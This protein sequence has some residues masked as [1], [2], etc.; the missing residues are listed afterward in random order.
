MAAQAFGAEV[1]ELGCRLALDDFGVGFGSFT[2]LRSLPISY[3]KI[4]RGFVGQLAHSA[5]DRRV[6]QGIV[7][8]ARSF[9]IEMIA[10]GIEDEQ[11]RDVLR[12]FGVDCVQGFLLGLPQLGPTAAGCATSTRSPG[13]RG[14]SGGARLDEMLDVFEKV[15]SDSSVEHSGRF[16]EIPPSTFDLRPAG[17]RAAEAGRDPG[18]LRRETRVNTHAGETMAET[19]EQVRESER[20][21]ADGVHVD[22]TYTAGSADQ[23]LEH[24]EELIG[25]LRV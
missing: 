24:A 5:E 4:D 17:G 12:E 18:A 7:S 3:I 10:E 21:G 1:T 16:W 6:V 13:C 25:L 14:R 8:V 22:F 2:Y 9:G 19:I 11:T 23:L 15:W 20:C